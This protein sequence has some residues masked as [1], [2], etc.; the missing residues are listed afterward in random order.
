[1]PANWRLICSAAGC[2]FPR[3]SSLDGARNVSRTRAGLG[4]GLE[5]VDSDID[6]AETGNLRQRSRRRAVCAPVT[7]T[8]SPAAPGLSHRRRTQRRHVSGPASAGAAVVPHRNVAGHSDV[9]HRRSPGHVPRD[10]HQSRVRVLELQARAELPLL[11][12]RR[13]R[14]RREV[15]VKTRRRRR[16]DLPGGARGSGIT[17][18]HFN[19]GF[20][21]TARPARR[22]AVRPRHQGER[23]TA[24][25]VQL[26]PREGLRVYDRLIDLGCRP[27]LVLPRTVRSAVV[28]AGL[29]REGADDSGSIDSSRR[30]TTAR[31]V[32]RAAPSQAR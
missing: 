22:G 21:G 7:V 14:R 20:Q 19:G 4:S 15:A 12:D 32:C 24:V 11:H 30:W 23:R 16:R 2:V 17:F 31:H 8:S 29:S 28:R 1:M 13:E 3:M 5:V 18:V 25:G 27:L 10:L 6:L 26:T 9:P